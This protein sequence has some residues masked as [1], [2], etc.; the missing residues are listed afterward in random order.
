MKSIYLNGEITYTSHGSSNWVCKKVTEK[1]G[2]I[3]D[4][5]YNLYYIPTGSND[6]RFHS[7]F[8][9]IPPIHEFKKHPNE[10]FEYPADSRM[11]WAVQSLDT[12]CLCYKKWKLAR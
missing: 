5:M 4:D 12:S 9:A 10:R 11:Y 3:R 7:R 8:Q 1:D 6:S 2:T